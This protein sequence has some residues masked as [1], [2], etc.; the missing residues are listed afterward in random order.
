MKRV[1]EGLI[2][3][4]AK[5][6]SIKK[7]SLSR[8]TYLNLIQAGI[9][10]SILFGTAVSALGFYG[11]ATGKGIV[12]TVGAGTISFDPVLSGLLTTIVGVLLTFEGIIL[13]RVSLQVSRLI[14]F[15][16][17]LGYCALNVPA[18]LLGLNYSLAAGVAAIIFGYL[19]LITIL[20]WLQRGE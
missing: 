4:I 12:F 1:L 15:S 6:K 13:M 20:A 16:I 3:K 5:I 11:L 2:S 19:W 17:I 10:L 7:I 8:S 14:V 18:I 9:G